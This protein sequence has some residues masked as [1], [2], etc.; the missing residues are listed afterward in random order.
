[1]PTPTDTDESGAFPATATERLTEGL[2]LS[3]DIVNQLLTAGPADLDDAIHR[4]LGDLG[5]FTQSDR[6]YVFRIRDGVALDNTHEW[7]AEGVEPVIHT[8]QNLPVSIADVWWDA[9]S[10]GEPVTI[11]DVDA[12]PNDRPEK[13]TLQDQG[14]R[15]LLAVP[16]RAHEG[17]GGFMGYDS[18]HEHRVFLQGEIDL[19]QNVA[20]VVAFTLEKRDTERRARLA[21]QD[22]VTQLLNRHALD[23]ILRQIIDEC[24]ET[25][26]HAA[27]FFLDL[28][29]FKAINDR[30]GHTVGD[31]V[32]RCVGDRLTAIQR[33]KDR[34]IRYGGD[35]FIVVVEELG[36]DLS[37][38]RLN[39]DRI[40]QRMAETVVEPMTVSSGSGQ[41]TLAVHVSIGAELFGM[42]AAAP[43]VLL[44]RADEAMYRAKIEGRAYEFAE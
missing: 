14:I 5:R 23:A 12:L 38:A 35:E 29:Q 44:T 3:V 27:L 16:L 4:A 8:L 6:T 7:C 2:A 31:Q 39:A 30:L 19:I 43:D 25:G 32:L 10:E 22:A 13:Q 28:N 15:S 1:M 41:E 36:T 24:R 34:V 11:D 9:F 20:N 33:T 42:E 17:F 40:A 26:S 21:R 18:V 37:E